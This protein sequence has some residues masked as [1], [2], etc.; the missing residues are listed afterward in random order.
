MSTISRERQSYRQN[1]LGNAS[2]LGT[3]LPPLSH[4]ERNEI[5]RLYRE[6][7]VI[8]GIKRAAWEENENDGSGLGI[9]W[10]IVLAIPCWLLIGYVAVASTWRLW[11]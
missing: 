2:D 11:Q 4:A 10:L 1:H 8:A 9:A 5:E 3:P 6:A 7:K